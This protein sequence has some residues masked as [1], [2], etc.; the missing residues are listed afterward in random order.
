M[1]NAEEA[2]L[3]ANV[4]GIGSNV[5]QRLR[6]GLEEQLEEDFLVLPHEWDQRM[7]NAEN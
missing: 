6:T 4:P 2:N 5:Q 1:Q 3:G 7:W